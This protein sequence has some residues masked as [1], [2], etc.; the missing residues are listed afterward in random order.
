MAMSGW[1]GLIYL[2]DRSVHSEE[3]QQKLGGRDDDIIGQ[4]I[5]AIDRVKNIRTILSSHFLSSTRDGSGLSLR[6]C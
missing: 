2:L 5:E 6:S 4:C 1:V 3:A